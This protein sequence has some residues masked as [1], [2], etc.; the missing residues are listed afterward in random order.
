MLDMRKQLLL[1]YFRKYTC[2]MFNAPSGCLKRE[3]L[4]PGGAYSGSLWDWDSYWATVALLG[5]ARRYLRGRERADSEAE[6]LRYAKGSL[7]NFFDHQAEDG[8][9]PILII[10]RFPDFFE[11]RDPRQNIGK[12]VHA[13][14]AA[15]LAPYGVFDE[16]EKTMILSGLRRLADCR[17]RRSQS[18]PT[19][20]FVWNT[21]AAIGVDDDPSTWG[22]P[23]NSSANIY[24]NSLIY[25]DFSA[26]ALLA[27]QWGDPA[28]QK[29]FSEQAAALKKAIRKY[30]FDR[31]D[32]LYYSVDVNCKVDRPHLG[33]L[34]LNANLD[35]FWHV[36]PLKVGS[37]CSLLPMWAKVATPAEAKA[38]VSGHLTNPERFWSPYGVRTLA[39]DEVM[40]SPEVRRGNPS[41]W[42][43][44]I[45]IISNYM[46]WRALK[47]YHFT[48]EA[49]E[50]SENTLNLL[51][52]DYQKNKYL[53]EYYSPA[54]GRGI[55][56]PRFINWN[57][58]ALL[59]D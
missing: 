33:D 48:A 47:Q 51:S 35:A 55:C 40:Y 23:H 12:P 2:R 57:L 25:A 24:L 4:D 39:A 11:T 54:S 36:L 41:N 50:L 3:F 18:M 7:L 1:E 44:P 20:L 42:L 9:M 15:L 38:M 14:F 29:W 59:M 34:I 52:R 8:S 5:I 31:R 46:V 56:G 45:W 22:R 16:A 58:L 6:T 30:C 26:A 37:W 17:I 13:Q 10:N 28:N 49:R 19:G 43:G 53:H 21:D 32:Q 27:G